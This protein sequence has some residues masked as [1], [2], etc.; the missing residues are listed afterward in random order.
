MRAVK[1][2]AVET[3]G[4]ASLS[5]GDEIIANLLDLTGGEA[6]GPGCWVV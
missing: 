5:R 3:S 4:I 2:H 6:T 1:F